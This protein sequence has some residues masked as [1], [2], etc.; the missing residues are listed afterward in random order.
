[1]PKTKIFEIP[2]KL[3]VFWDSEAKATIDAWTNYKVTKDEFSNAVLNKGLA[4]ARA[5]NGIA[6]I[7]DSS[8]AEGTFSQEIQDFI[9]TDVF[10]AFTK[11]NIKYFITIMSKSAMTNMGIKRFAAKTGPL[12]LQLV[13]VDSLPSAVDW[14]KKNAR[15]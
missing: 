3:S 5:N 4:H 14:L 6:H 11:A 2:G 1:M 13:S 12:G 7:V 8:Q 15:P 9:G 10:P